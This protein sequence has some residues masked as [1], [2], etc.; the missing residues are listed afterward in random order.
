MASTAVD[1]SKT[2]VPVNMKEC[3]KYNRCRPDF[4]A[5]SPRVVVSEAGML[6][7]EE[8]DNE[9]DEAF[10]D[11]DVEWRAMRYY[12]SSKVLGELYRAIDEQRFLAKLQQEQKAHMKVSGSQND[13]LDTLLKYMKRQATRYGVL[14]DHHRELAL[15]IRA[16]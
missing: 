11:L 7:F 9:D 8:E 14:F 12:S 2:G 3:P 6:D 15:D 1:F 10:E 5:P 16:G 4:M 13:L